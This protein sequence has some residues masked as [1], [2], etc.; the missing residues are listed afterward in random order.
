VASRVRQTFDASRPGDCDRRGGAFCVRTWLVAEPV[1][2]LPNDLVEV[3]DQRKRSPL[4]L[5]ENAPDRRPT[6]SK[7]GRSMPIAQASRTLERTLGVLI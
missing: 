5:F 2:L 4:C 7:R 1:V 3:T 6:A